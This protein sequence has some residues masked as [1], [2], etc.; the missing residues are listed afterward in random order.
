MSRRVLDLAKHS[1]QQ[2]THKLTCL[3]LDRFYALDYSLNVRPLPSR[4]IHDAGNAWAQVTETL[5]MGSYGKI[6]VSHLMVRSTPSP[7][8]T[9]IREPQGTCPFRKPANSA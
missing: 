6:S 1:V 5:I 4:L 8:S 9:P 7:L 2:T 3:A